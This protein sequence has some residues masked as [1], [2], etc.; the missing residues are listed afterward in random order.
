MSADTLVAITGIVM[1][2]VLVGANGGL[3]RLPRQR[4]LGM[5]AIWLVVILVAALAFGFVRPPSI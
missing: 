3:R 5:A 2:L 1:A 4:M